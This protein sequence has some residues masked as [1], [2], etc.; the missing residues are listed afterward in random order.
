LRS[1]V[2]EEG[3]Q[4]VNANMIEKSEVCSRCQKFGISGIIHRLQ[5]F[6]L[7]RTLLARPFY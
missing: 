2:I 4:I 6:T 3:M 5:Y 7:P 1:N